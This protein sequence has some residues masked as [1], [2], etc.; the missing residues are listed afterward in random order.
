MRDHLRL[1]SLEAED[2]AKH[3]R[4][5]CEHNGHALEH[6][7]AQLFLSLRR[8]IERYRTLAACKVSA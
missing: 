4:D 5:C 6:C 1:K 7:L 2:S 8:V 3:D